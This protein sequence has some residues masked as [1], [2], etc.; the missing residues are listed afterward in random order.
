MLHPNQPKPEDFLIGVQHVQGP[1]RLDALETI[2]IRQEESRRAAAVYG[3]TPEF[4]NLHETWF[5]LGRQ[6]V[7]FYDPR[8]KMI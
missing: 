2:Q 1:Y 6:E 4:L 7:Y 5:W 8:W 3:A